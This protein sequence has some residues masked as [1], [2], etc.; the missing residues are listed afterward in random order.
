ML[1]FFLKQSLLWVVDALFLHFTRLNARQSTRALLNKSSVRQ[2][3][4]DDIEL[5]NLT[6]SAVNG[7][8]SGAERQS[9]RSGA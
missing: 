6:V 8:T 2:V 9:G 1:D 3:D 5:S 4:L 7:Q